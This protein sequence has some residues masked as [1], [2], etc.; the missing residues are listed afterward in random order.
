MG[1]QL[2]YF[3]DDEVIG[4]DQELCAMLD[5]AR[6]LAQVP[7]KITSGFRTP[8][9]NDELPNSVKDSAHLTGNAVDLAC[10][11]SV[12]RYAMVTAL[13]QSGFNRIGIYGL[14]VHADNSKTLPQGVIWWSAGI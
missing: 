9:K 5:R 10:S 2:T 1:Q 7:F 11:D 4:L 6:G 3:T 13:L 14:H 12:E 8:D